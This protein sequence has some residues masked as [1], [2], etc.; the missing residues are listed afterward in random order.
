MRK[1][2]CNVLD[3]CFGRLLVAL[4]GCVF[5][6]PAGRCQAAVVKFADHVHASHY[7]SPGAPITFADFYGGTFPG[8]GGVDFPVLVPLSV[9]LG[10]DPASPTFASPADFLSLPL[11][12]FIVVDFIGHV[13]VDVFGPDIFIREVGA[14]AER[15]RVSVSDDGVNFTVLRKEVSPGVLEEHLAIVPDSGS[16]FAEFAFDLTPVGLVSARFLK[17][18]G[19]DQGGGS[20]PGFDLMNVSAFVEL[21]QTTVTPE[22]ASLSLWAMAGIGLVV[23]RRQMGRKRRS[24]SPK[25]E[26]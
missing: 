8:V 17:I 26:V 19:V 3:R 9:A 24:A 16:D 22:P 5:F 15:A 18:E 12:S 25:I 4:L 6:A 2:G 13:V 10:S 14:N 1:R 7:V 11:G 20:S 21:A 23:A